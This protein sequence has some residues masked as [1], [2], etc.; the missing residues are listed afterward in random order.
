MKRP[1]VDPTPIPT[2]PGKWYV[3][4]TPELTECCGC[5]LVHHTEYKLDENGRLLWRARE[6][7]RATRAARK[8]EGIR[9][10]RAPVP[11]RDAP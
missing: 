6:D 7:K 3:L 10:E 5:G 4:R 2:E 9:I 1:K 11:P 8:R